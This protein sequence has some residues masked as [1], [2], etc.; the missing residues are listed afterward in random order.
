MC[1]KALKKHEIY[2]DVTKPSMKVE[3]NQA[4]LLRY[5]L[6]GLTKRSDIGH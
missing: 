5:L 3:L 1:S 4:L 6:I 2:P